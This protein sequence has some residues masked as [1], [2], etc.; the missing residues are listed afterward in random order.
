MGK[1]LKLG[2]INFWP[3]SLLGVIMPEHSTTCHKG[4][5]HGR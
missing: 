2:Q 4:G 1:I 3:F 5:S